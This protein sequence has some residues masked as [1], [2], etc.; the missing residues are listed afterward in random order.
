MELCILLLILLPFIIAL[1]QFAVRDPQ[2]RRIL[3]YVG[4]GAIMATALTVAGP[5]F[6]RQM[7]CQILS[8]ALNHGTYYIKICR[9]NAPVNQTDHSIT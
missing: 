7:P 6:A 4:S 1:G 3:T 9:R 5:H 8:A 2:K